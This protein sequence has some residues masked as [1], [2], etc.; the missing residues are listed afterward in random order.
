[1][2]ITV[3]ECGICCHSGVVVFYSIVGSEELGVCQ[4]KF[5][6][7]LKFAAVPIQILRVEICNYQRSAG[8]PVS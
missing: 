6:V 5:K 7:R 3:Y 1:M 8:F 2:R 4:T